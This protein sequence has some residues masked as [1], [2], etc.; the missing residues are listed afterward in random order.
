MIYYSLNVIVNFNQIPAY[1]H[2]LP[3]IQTATKFYIYLFCL[4]LQS[5][6]GFSSIMF[7]LTSDLLLVRVMA[8]AFTKTKNATTTPEATNLLEVLF[9]KVLKLLD[10]M[11]RLSK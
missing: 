4:T 3:F 8:V 7:E 5:Y 11:D 1:N 10:V 9:D 6:Y 2:I